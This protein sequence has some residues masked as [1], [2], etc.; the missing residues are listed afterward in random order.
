MIAMQV[1][2]AIV[3][4]G[5]TV[6]PV[7]QVNM[8][9]PDLLYHMIGDSYSIV[10]ERGLFLDVN[11]Y[12][13]RNGAWEP[14]IEPFCFNE[15][16]INVDRDGKM[17][18]NCGGTIKPLLINISPTPLQK[19]AWFGPYFLQEAFA[20]NNNTST[21][22]ATTT[23][24]TTRSSSGVLLGGVSSPSTSGAI[25]ANTDGNANTYDGDAHVVN[26]VREQNYRRE[27]EGDEDEQSRY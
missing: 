23:T 1:E 18:F 27:Q 13:T 8:R 10:T 9:L 7:L 22:S 24:T 14:L 3:T 20:S 4:L 16:A 5:D 15:F 12:N 19:L 25:G 17:V 2:H 11:Q 26:R 21:T 6:I